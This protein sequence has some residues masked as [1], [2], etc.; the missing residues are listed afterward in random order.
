MLGNKWAI[1]NVT[2]LFFHLKQ[3]FGNAFQR[4]RIAAGLH[5]KIGGGDIRRAQ[6]R[7]L[8][9]IL[10]VG[11]TLQRPLFQRVKHDNRYATTSQFVQRPHHTRVVGSRI[12]ADGNHQL[13][14]VKIIQRHR[15]LPDADRLRQPDAGRFMAHIG[16]VREIVG[17]QFTGKQLEQ[18]RRFVGG[19]PGSIELDLVR[20]HAADYF[21]DTRKSAFP[22]GR[23]QRVAGAIVDQRMG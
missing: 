17:A 7:H 5:L 11:K 18:P 3:R 16:T 10:R 21:A 1:E 6:G 8:D 15:S 9:N 13:G 19:A 20:L 12:M 4:R 22:A 14:F 23:A 2:L